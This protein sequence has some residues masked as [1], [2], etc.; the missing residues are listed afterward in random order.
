MDDE[1]RQVYQDS[2][3]HIILGL[4]FIGLV[5]GVIAL[6]IEGPTSPW[7]LRAMALL[8]VVVVALIL[9]RAG[10]FVVAA[11][12]LVLELISIVAGMLLQ[13]NAL[14]GFIPYL[15]IPIIIMASLILSPNAILALAIFSIAGALAMVAVSG[16]FTLFNLLLLLPPFGV[17][18]LTALISTLSGRYVVKVDNRLQISQKLLRERTL[19][20]LRAQ[21]DIKEFQEKSETVKEQLVKIKTETSQARQMAAQKDHRFYH[22]IK[23]TISELKAS[24][25]KLE[26]VMEAMAERPNSTLL[27]EAWQ[28]TDHL[29]SLVVGLEE[30]TELEN[31]EVRL[32]CQPVEVAQLL[33][34]VIQTTR[35]LV[36]EKN[37]ELRC[38]ISENLPMLVAD[39]ARLRQALL[40][41]L[42]NAIKYTDKGLIEVQTELA[43]SELT[44]FISDTGIGMSAEELST[45]FQHFGRGQSPLAKQRAGTGLGLSLSKR[46]IEMHK[47]RLWATSVLGVGSTFCVALP[48]Q[49][50]LEQTMLSWPAVTLPAVIAPNR[51]TQPATI[52]ASPVKS[53]PTRLT[54]LNDMVVKP[55][56][57]A[58]AEPALSQT[59]ANFTPVAR[60]SPVYISRFGLTLLGLLLIITGLVLAL[61]LS[62]GPNKSEAKRSA[63]TPVSSPVKVANNLSTPQTPILAET[64]TR[65]PTMTASAT[66]T[67]SQM[68][69][70]TLLASLQPQQQLETVQPALP[71]PTP[72]RATSTPTPSSTASPTPLP[73]STLTREPTR[74]ATALTVTA[75]SV[76]I[77]NQVTL[78]IPTEFNQ[79]PDLTLF[80]FNLVPGAG[81]IVITNPIANSGLSWLHTESG[82]QA[83]FSKDSHSNRDIYLTRNDSPLLNLTLAD[84]DDLQPAGSPDGRQIVFSS[85][86][87]GNLDI[88]VMDTKGGNPVQLTNSR[89]FDEWP[90]WSPDGRQLAFVSDRD[91]NV[92]I[93][94]M[95]ADGSQQQRLTNDPAD[96]WP[97]TWSPDGQRL[98][99]ASNRDSNWNLYLLEIKDRQPTRLTN[100]PGDE[101]DPIWS[102]D[103][104]TLVFAYN[105]SGNWDIYTIPA[106]TGAPTEI[107]RSQWTQ[108]T[109]TSRDERYPV[110]LP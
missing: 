65:V 48:L 7:F 63:A 91:G 107:P 23:G 99:F 68:P 86:R 32:N 22:L 42:S 43:A 87:S 73:T 18:I 85:G 45:I 49:A 60:F 12:L 50:D 74:V 105:G 20:M 93:Y 31:D 34:E 84:G 41:L 94:L 88:Y 26:L 56:R 39:P 3:N 106:P 109:A 37:L 35:G 71:T 108:V 66:P 28:N 58:A 17:L 51:E 96:D 1:V 110:W 67:P 14:T 16:Q 69:T 53:E 6:I 9:R 2:F 36:W 75:Q 103:G 102:P 27:H 89:G 70:A 15:F 44:I 4:S 62:N 78:P 59:Q 64:A 38:S 54:S 98:L 101:R 21:E 90:A 47:G 81:L 10:Q 46:I 55:P 24:V 80:G 11:Y 57:P 25:K 19:G 79:Y 76:V 13:A 82:Y 92:E 104:R 77:P 52:I 95:H 5:G 97:V 30:I 100:D 29:S 72:V 33:S 61:A 8:L 40:H 83:L